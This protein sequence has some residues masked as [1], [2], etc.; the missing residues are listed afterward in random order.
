MKFNRINFILFSSISLL[1]LTSV[2]FN[3]CQYKQ[4]N[5]LSGKIASGLNTQ[6]KFVGDSDPSQNTT[7]QIVIAEP[8]SNSDTS[9]VA[10]AKKSNLH[11]YKIKDSIKNE[12]DELEYQLNAAEEDA[13]MA[14]NQ[15]SE[16]LTK[17]DEY[18]KAMNTLNNLLSYESLEKA[19]DAS[20]IRMA[21]LYN[22]LLRELNI[23]EEEFEKFKELMIDRTK[24]AMYFLY[25]GDISDEERKELIR[26]S[27]ELVISY[28]NKIF[29]LLGDGN[30][31]VYQSFSMK[32]PEYSDLNEFNGTLPVDIRLTEEQ[33]DF[34][35]EFTYEERH[36]DTLPKSYGQKE[37]MKKVLEITKLNNAKY[38]EAS[39]RV[40][41]PEQVE[42]YKDFL[43]KKVD[44]QEAS[45]KIQKFLY[46]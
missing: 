18:K 5:V 34:L 17:K 36:T 19:S 24:G 13:D 3:L 22:P 41:T 10:T 15:L 30:Y 27:N 26:E 39:S 2:G 6:N 32:I 25:D 40:L 31:E 44:K 1:L 38:L 29:E 4:I 45:I 46:D 8:E 23:S 37:M 14:Y 21:D 42:L 35:A 12:I 11:G 16:E 7:E 43:Q 20:A 9:N 33:M 28:D